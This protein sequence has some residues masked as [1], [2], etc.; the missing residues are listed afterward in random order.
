MKTLFALLTIAL[1]LSAAAL[2]TTV[3]TTFTH[4]EGWDEVKT[5]SSDGQQFVIAV[6]LGFSTG[7]LIT[8]YLLRR[9]KK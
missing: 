5:N 4:S 2:A 1:V 3:E 9:L 8:I 7:A 6:I